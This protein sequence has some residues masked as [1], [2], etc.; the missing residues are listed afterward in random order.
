MSERPATTKRWPHPAESLIGP[1]TSE[2]RR[3]DQAARPSEP[4]AS[5]WR[6]VDVLSVL[7]HRQL[8]GAA[9]NLAELGGAEV[10]HRTP[11]FAA[12]VVPKGPTAKRVHLSMAE[13][14]QHTDQSPRLALA[15]SVVKRRCLQPNR[16]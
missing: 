13:M 9:L 3:S 15:H 4:A 7:D 2:Y 16:I 5:V 6:G 11:I 14:Q 8:A 12:L 1:E 10:P